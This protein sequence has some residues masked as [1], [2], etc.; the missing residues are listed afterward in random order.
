MLTKMCCISFVFFLRAS[1]ML[2]LKKEPPEF[3]PLG[4]LGETPKACDPSERLR[5][6]AQSARRLGANLPLLFSQAS[7]KK[8]Q[9]E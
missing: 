9:K 5:L 6:R 7:M 4:G 3:E 2:L 1:L 8:L